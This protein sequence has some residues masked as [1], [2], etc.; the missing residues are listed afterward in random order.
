MFAHVGSHFGGGMVLAR[1]MLLAMLLVAILLPFGV[2]LAHTHKHWASSIQVGSRQEELEVGSIS[3]Q[4]VRR[5]VKTLS[6]V[7]KVE[8]ITNFLITTRVPTAGL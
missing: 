3:E 7:Y 6:T 4:A 1:W 2:V 5:T 8:S